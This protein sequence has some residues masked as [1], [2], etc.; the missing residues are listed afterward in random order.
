MHF[1]LFH[2]RYFAG[3]RANLNVRSHIN[4]TLTISIIA[5]LISLGS[6]AFNL[7]QFRTT[8]KLRLLE[9]ANDVSHRAFLLRKLS[10]DLRN[11][12]SVTDDVPDMD[13]MLDRLDNAI[14][15]GYG[16]LLSSEKLSIQDAFEL[17]RH[18][19]E[20]DLEYDLLSKQVD[21][22]ANFNNEVKVLRQ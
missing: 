21:V 4:M 9:K 18:L 14:E 2:V 6:L 16:K 17:E 3:H 8:R 13:Y 15:S 12:V 22:Q 11:K 20:L 5:I 10:Q 19:L 7:Y 1:V